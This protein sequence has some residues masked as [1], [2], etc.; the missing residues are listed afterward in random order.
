MNC[1]AVLTLAQNDTA[2]VNSSVNFVST[3]SVEEI[4]VPITLPTTPGTFV[5]WLDIF[6]DNELFGAYVGNENVEVAGSY[7]IQFTGVTVSP[8]TIQSNSGWW[9]TSYYA[10]S[11][12]QIR[13][14]AAQRVPSEGESGSANISVQ[15]QYKAGATVIVNGSYTTTPQTLLPSGSGYYFPVGNGAVGQPYAGVSLSLGSTKP[16]TG[17]WNYTMTVTANVGGVVKGMAVFEGTVQVA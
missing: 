6:I 9:G 17:T 15:F 14:N 10:V 7:P 4:I 11:W 8:F 2:V 1:L 13:W 3:G 16:P 5:P 12:H